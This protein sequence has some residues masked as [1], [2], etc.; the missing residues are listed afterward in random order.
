MQTVLMD[1]LHGTAIRYTARVGDSLLAAVHFTVTTDPEHPVALDAAAQVELT[2]ALRGH[3]PDLGGPA[4]RR[5]GACGGG[6]EDLDTA[7]ALTRYG[8]AFDQAYKEDYGV[9]DAVYDLRQLDGLAGPDDLALGFTNSDGRAEDR[10]LKLYVT[11]GT[12]TLSRVLPVLQSLGAEVI[13]ERPYEVRRSDGTPSRIYDFGLRFSP[14]L[15]PDAEGLPA[16]RER[17][18]EGLHRDLESPGGGRRVQRTG[19]GGRPGLASDRG[20]ARLCPLS[21]ADRNALHTGV[22]RTGTDRPPG[23]HRRS[24]G[25]VRGSFRSPGPSGQHRRHRGGL[26]IG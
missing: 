9:D 25:A 18:F 7:A 26:P 4:G 22:S 8:E 19:A 16:A 2:K 17:V 13:D 12:V 15:V 5:R 21:A 11:G 3:H 24:G 14:G 10:R 6:D 1:T 20:A 23:D